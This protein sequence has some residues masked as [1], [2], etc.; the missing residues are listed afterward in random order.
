V[1]LD[2]EDDRGD[3][4]WSESQAEAVSSITPIEKTKTLSSSG[5]LLPAQQRLI[6]L[7]GIVLLRD[8]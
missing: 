2:A 4:R 8:R 5:R 3:P 7:A 1:H 6:L